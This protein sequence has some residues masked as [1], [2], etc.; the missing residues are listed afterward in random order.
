MAA[1]RRRRPAR[2]RDHRPT[3]PA[4]STPAT[5]RPCAGS[6]TRAAARGVAVGAQ[7][8]YRDLAGFGRRR[9]DYDVGRAARRR[10]LPDRRAGRVL[11]GRPATGCGTSSRTARSTTRPP[12]TRGRRRRWS[13]RSSDYD[14]ALPVLCQP[15]S[16]LASS[17]PARGCTVVGEGFADRGYLADGRLV[18]RSAAGRPG[19]PI[20]TRSPRGRCGW[21]SRQ[22]VERSTAR[23]CRCRSRRS[24]CTA[25]RRARSSWR[26]RVRAALVDARRCRWRRSRLS[27]SLISSRGQPSWRQ[28]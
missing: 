3:S 2:R 17:P 10:A 14:A 7:V 26:R 19:R 28:L 23:W 24:A 27:E 6:A 5:R 16:V 15:G 25:T 13:R 1:R 8:G 11:P 21:P 20:R 18:P 4:A 12:S 9:I 22:V